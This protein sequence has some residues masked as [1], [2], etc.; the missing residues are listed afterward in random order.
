M[1][2]QGRLRLCTLLCSLP[3][4]RTAATGSGTYCAVP[5]DR[6]P[7]AAKEVLPVGEVTSGRDL[8][9]AGRLLYWCAEDVHL[10]KRRD[11]RYIQI[12]LLA[13]CDTC[14]SPSP[15]LALCCRRMLKRPAV[16]LARTPPR[17]HGLYGPPVRCDTRPSLRLS[18]I[19]SQSLDAPDQRTPFEQCSALVQRQALTST[20]G[21][22]PLLDLS[23]NAAQTGSHRGGS[24]HT[25]L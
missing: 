19:A 20:P 11:G 24:L 17:R 12:G 10:A 18:L 21:A 16:R 4:T 13:Q 3:D 22:V 1:D 5:T 9:A 14:P 7:R 8:E 25:R 15:T 23:R 2:I 6:L